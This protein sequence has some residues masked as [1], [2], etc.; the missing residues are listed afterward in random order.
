[1][2][3]KN[4]LIEFIEKKYFLLKRKL[5]YF[6]RDEKISFNIN[7]INDG[8]A[9]VTYR[10]VQTIKC[11]F[12]YVMYQM[13]LNEIKPDLVIEIGS[14]SGGNALYMADIM[15]TLGKGIVHTIDIK[16]P[17]AD[18]VVN[19]PR[20]KIFDKGWEGYKVANAKE[21]LK[22]LVIDDASHV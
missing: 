14:S 20:I 15:N 18:L 22:I 11:P 6:P 16:R 2:P 8:H 10:G 21:F 13:I 5:Q 19:H 4:R 1:M 3:K 12:D 7:T 17:T 9:Q